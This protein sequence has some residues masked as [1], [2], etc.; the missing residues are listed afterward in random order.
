MRYASNKHIQRHSV[1]TVSDDWDVD[2]GG[3]CVGQQGRNQISAEE[4]DEG[5]T[6][7]KWRGKAQNPQPLAHGYSTR[8]MTRSCGIH[9]LELWLRNCFTE[10]LRASEHW[11]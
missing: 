1:Q 3:A 4:R 11:T 5:G 6:R 7:A 10:V 8:R 2:P 9:R